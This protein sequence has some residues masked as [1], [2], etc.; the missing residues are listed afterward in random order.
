VPGAEF[1]MRYAMLIHHDEVAL[2]EA[3]PSLRGDYP[4]GKVN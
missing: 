3:S 2:A 1:T 4:V